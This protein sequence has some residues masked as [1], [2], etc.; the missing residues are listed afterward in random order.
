VPRVWPNLGAKPVPSV[1]TSEPC[2]PSHPL[3][4]FLSSGNKHRLIVRIKYEWQMINV[5]AVLTHTQYD[6]NRWK[7]S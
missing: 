2:I 6:Q 5:R 1:H 7:E 3:S 4:S